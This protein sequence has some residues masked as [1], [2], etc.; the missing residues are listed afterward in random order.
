MIKKIVMEM[1]ILFCLK[2][3]VTVYDVEISKDLI[4]ESFDFYLS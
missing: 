1:L 2:K 4:L 3:L